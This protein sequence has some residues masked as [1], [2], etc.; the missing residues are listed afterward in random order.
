MKT[1]KVVFSDPFSSVSFITLTNLSTECA[2]AH[3]CT[4]GKGN[5]EGSDM[6][7]LLAKD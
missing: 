1:C 7:L 3:N 2:A 5:E 4:H 6:F